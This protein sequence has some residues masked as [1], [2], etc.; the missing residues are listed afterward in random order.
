MKDHE[1]ADDFLSTIFIF[2][3][4]LYTVDAGFFGRSWSDDKICDASFYSFFFC[5][6]ELRRK[7]GH[8]GQIVSCFDC[9]V[10]FVLLYNMGKRVRGYHYVSLLL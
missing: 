1:L 4:K 7:D 2:L 6:R 9:F 3:A 8:E 5:F 10:Y